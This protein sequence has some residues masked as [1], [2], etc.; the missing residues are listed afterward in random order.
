MKEDGAGVEDETTVSRKSKSKVG[1]AGAVGKVN[2]LL[3]NY[4]KPSIMV[5]GNASGSPRSSR[6]SVLQHASTI[7]SVGMGTLSAS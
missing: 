6:K 7:D 1:G 4:A 3:S 2:A 5:G